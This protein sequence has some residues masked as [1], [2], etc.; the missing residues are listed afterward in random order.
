LDE[1][2]QRAP[3][4]AKSLVEDLSGILNRQS[5]G[6]IRF[7]KLVGGSLRAHVHNDGA[8]KWSPR[9]DFLTQANYLLPT[10]RSSKVTDEKQHGGG[11][12]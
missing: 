4:E 8:R 3:G 11:W 1:L 9:F 6:P 2:L 7:E 10:E 5:V 12:L